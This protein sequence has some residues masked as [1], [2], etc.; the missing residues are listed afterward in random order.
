MEI[1]L[2]KLLRK[3]KVFKNRVQSTQSAI[4]FGASEK[5]R[6]NKLNKVANFGLFGKEWV[7]FNN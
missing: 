2:N 3:F 6:K 4:D 7:D 5:I 1:K